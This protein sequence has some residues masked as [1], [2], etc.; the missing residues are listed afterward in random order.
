M[1]TRPPS[2]LD[3][4]RASLFIPRASQV[5]ELPFDLPYSGAS[6][7]HAREVLR[8]LD[9]YIVLVRALPVIPPHA[10]ERGGQEEEE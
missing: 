8:M 10:G 7:E 6:A 4:R 3:V 5:S 9:D 2:H 1:A